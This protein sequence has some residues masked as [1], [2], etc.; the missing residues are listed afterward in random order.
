MLM[1]VND[2][3]TVAPHKYSKRVFFTCRIFGGGNDG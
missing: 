2:D 3:L 1:K